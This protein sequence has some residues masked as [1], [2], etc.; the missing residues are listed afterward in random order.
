[1]FEKLNNTKLLIG[2]NNDMYCVYKIYKKHKTPI[3]ITDN[4][5]KA[6][7][8]LKELELY[9]KKLLEKQYNR[10]Q[11]DLNVLNNKYNNNTIDLLTKIN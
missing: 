7:N 6:N 11:N 10:L 3:I 9:K 2:E 8:K 4:F 5:D 1:M